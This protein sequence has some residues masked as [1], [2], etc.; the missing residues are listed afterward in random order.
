MT[1][2]LPTLLLAAFFAVQWV[3]E[4]AEMVSEKPGYASTLTSALHSIS[5]AQ[6]AAGT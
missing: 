1:F 6:G 2:D 5:H 4:K 3:F